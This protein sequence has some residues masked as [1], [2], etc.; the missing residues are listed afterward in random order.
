MGHKEFTVTA[1]RAIIKSHMVIIVIA[2]ESHIK[3]VEEETILLFSIA[4]RFFSFS[5]HSIVH[6][7]ISFQDRKI[8]S[9]RRRACLLAR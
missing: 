8:K 4:F 1:K 7:L 5:D 3:L 9:T 2:M 6:C